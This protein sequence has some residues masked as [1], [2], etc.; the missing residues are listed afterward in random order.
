MESGT[1]KLDCFTNKPLDKSIL[2]L[3]NAL[4]NYAN[5][6]ILN[7]NVYVCITVIDIGSISVIT[8]I[9]FIN[10][11][12]NITT[13][14]MLIPPIITNE[15]ADNIHDAWKNEVKA[16]IDRKKNYINQ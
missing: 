4:V 7:N 5:N 6:Y 15:I 1:C 10:A 9:T 14:E 16:I 13:L 8:D 3:L 2:N 11:T 12:Y